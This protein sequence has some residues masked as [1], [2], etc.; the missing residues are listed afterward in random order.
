LEC[1]KEVLVKIAERLVLV[2]VTSLWF[3]Y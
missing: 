2:T 3:K 1:V